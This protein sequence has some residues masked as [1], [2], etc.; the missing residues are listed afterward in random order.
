MSKSHPSPTHVR[1]TQEQDSLLSEAAKLSGLPKSEL[2]RCCVSL[3]LRIL[4]QHDYDVY[5]TLA[6]ALLPDARSNGK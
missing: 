2:V 6:E 5:Q 3:G 1:F 4:R